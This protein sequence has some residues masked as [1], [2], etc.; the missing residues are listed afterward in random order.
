L[1]CP[2]AI[3]MNA[4]QSEQATMDYIKSAETSGYGSTPAAPPARSFKLLPIAVDGVWGTRRRAAGRARKAMARE[5]KLL[6][7][8]SK[9]KFAIVGKR[10]EF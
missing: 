1:H 9:T 4:A 2:P 7:R 10:T 6:A 3:C 5:N 8:V